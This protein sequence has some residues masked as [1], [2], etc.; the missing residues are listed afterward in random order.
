VL[1]RPKPDRVTTRL[2]VLGA[3]H[4]A[5]FTRAEVHDTARAY[6]SDAEFFDMGHDMMLE[7]GWAAVAERICAWLGERGL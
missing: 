6:R 1:N 4:D 5:C 7:P 3:E 2:L